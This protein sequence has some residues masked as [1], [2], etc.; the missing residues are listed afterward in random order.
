MARI[1]GQETHCSG[2]PQNCDHLETVLSYKIRRIRAKF[3]Y[4]VHVSGLNVDNDW[5]YLK[6]VYYQSFGDTP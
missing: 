2:C 3:Q 5:E 6:L 4:G 1:V